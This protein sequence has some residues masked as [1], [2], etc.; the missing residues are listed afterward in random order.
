M[1]LNKPQYNTWI[2]LVYDQNQADVLK[3]A[4]G[5]VDNG[6]PPGI[7]M[8]DDNWQKYYG[9][10]EFRPDRFPDPKGMV[11]ELH[12]LG[13]DMSSL[14]GGSYSLQGMPAGFDGVDPH[15][16]LGDII[17]N[18]KTRGRLEH[19]ASS[20]ASL[21]VD[22][23]HRMALT[24]ARSAAIPVGGVLSTQEMENLVDELFQQ[25][26]PNFTP[27]GRTI[28]VIFPHENLEKLFK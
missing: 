2:E 22:L 5:I 8:I 18:L 9:S 12:A 15:R 11:D 4:H 24:M 6:F 7:L 3:Y 16:L 26:E 20:A 10:T 17:E 19:V 28:V 21:G 27:D 1:F 13:F 14:G 25:P 23:H